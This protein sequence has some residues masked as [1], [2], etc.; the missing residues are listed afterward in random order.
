MVVHGRA[1][2]QAGRRSPAR[3]LTGTGKKVEHVPIAHDAA[4][5]PQT[6]I[7]ERITVALV[8]QANGDL[9]KLQDRTTLSKTDLVNRAITLYEFIQGELS[10]GRQL[11]IRDPE[12]KQEQ[13]VR[14]L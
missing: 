2:A 10:A 5:A 11:L 14:I 1:F 3:C 9:R 7:V 4:T 12:S 13:L 8:P 6:A